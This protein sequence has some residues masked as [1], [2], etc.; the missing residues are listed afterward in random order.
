MPQQ[1]FDW[2]KYPEVQPQRVASAPPVQ[3]QP[4]QPQQEESFWSRLLGPTA[5]TWNPMTMLGNTVDTAKGLG[6]IGKQAIGDPQFAGQLVHGLQNPWTMLA[7]PGGR[8]FAAGM[9]RAMWDAATE[10]AVEGW[11]KAQEGDY[12]GATGEA[13][14]AGTKLASTVYGGPLMGAVA[15]GT[16]LSKIPNKL[17]GM[18]LRVGGQTQRNFPDV[19]IPAAVIKFGTP[20]QQSAGRLGRVVENELNDRVGHLT[21]SQTPVPAGPIIGRAAEQTVRDVRIPF[22]IGTREQS[23]SNLEDLTE[24][25]LHDARNSINP[26]TL[27]PNSNPFEPPSFNAQE[28]LEGKRAAQRQASMSRDQLGNFANKRSDVDESMFIN[29]GNE[30]KG[31]LDDMFR[32]G[33]MGSSNDLLRLEQELLAI[34]EAFSR[35]AGQGSHFGQA[36]AA[37]GLGGALMTGTP[38]PLMRGGLTAGVANVLA[39]PGGLS[40]IG[41]GMDRAGQL[42]SNPGAFGSAALLNAIL[43]NYGRQDHTNMQPQAS[44]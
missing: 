28:L 20:N 4:Q 15:R 1:P 27:Q 7:T 30:M 5:E 9:G 19:D 44:H 43:R 42:A 22:Q 21:S 16:G 2:N 36:A 17:V 39:N 14:D 37:S 33:G 11:G 32:R 41:I 34:Q 13:I 6:A 35:R 8:Q 24:R 26:N 31:E 25:M 23:I 29:L 3:P 40:R 12:V 10:D 38:S 18:G